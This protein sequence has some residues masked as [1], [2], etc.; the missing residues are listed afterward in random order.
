LSIAPTASVS[1]TIEAHVI[2][3]LNFGI[4]ALDNAVSA[5]V[6]LD[7]DTSASM[8]ASAQIGAVASTTVGSPGATTNSSVGGCFEIDSEFS[9]N[10]GAEGSFFDLFDENTKVPLF[11]KKFQLFKVCLLLP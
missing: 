8:T 1:A 5:T 11:D 4:S 9:V 3:S 7:L 6:F 2:P 10:A